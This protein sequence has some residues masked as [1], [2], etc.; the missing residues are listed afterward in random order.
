MTVP[1]A[2]QLGVSLADYA[3]DL[4]RMHHAVIGGSRSEL[5]PRELV[6]LGTAA[7]TEDLGR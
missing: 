7:G 6:A 3:R 4:V 1:D 5:R 2:V